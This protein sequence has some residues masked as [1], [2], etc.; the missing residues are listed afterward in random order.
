MFDF[1]IVGAGSAGCVLANRLSNGG[2]KVALI[3]AGGS[4]H[5][6]LKVRAP[7]LYQLLWS[8]P[9]DWAFKTK[10]QAHCAN[11]SH[12]WPRGKLIGGTSCLNAMVYIRG[13]RKNYDDWGVPG[14]SYA[15][16]LPY[17]KKSEDNVRGASEFHGAGGL[18]HVSNNDAPSDFAKAFVEATSAH[19]KVPVNDDFNGADQE[20]PGHYQS[21]IKKGQRAS[22]AIA[23]L[24]PALR[25]ENLT[26]MSGAHALGL[27]LDGDRVKGVRIRTAKGEQ[28][29]EG[30][31]IILAGGAIGS[32]HLLLLSG[33]GP[34]SELKAAGVEPKHELAGVGKNLQDHLLHAVNFEAASSPNLQKAAMLWWIA[35]FAMTGGGPLTGAALDA[36]AFIRSSPSAPLPDIQYHVA[37]FGV[38]LP[39]DHGVVNPSF[40]RFACILPGLIYPKSTGEICLASTDPTAPPA[41]DPK[42]F[43]DA[44]DLDLLVAGVKQS[45]EI[46]NT[47][48]LEQVLGKEIY[49]GP[50]ATSDEQLRDNI[51]AGCNT[52]FHPVGTCK[53]GTGSDAVVGPDLRV[54]GLR[55]LRVADA[56][57]MPK[58]VGGNT[59]APTIMIAEKCAELALQA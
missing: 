21:T 7:R 30:N 28:T 46:A 9:I 20:G 50:E 57:I 44:A 24:E 3:E 56:S 8:T 5:K 11:R 47:G 36:G 23:F 6:S 15:D 37:P 58:I 14:W 55:G 40:G 25:R 12:F 1:V 10:P 32:P 29:I 54:H 31:E 41:I 19:C 34:A 39:S 4:Q 51:R 48:A 17:F 2:R 59:N 22:T 53:M 52:I 26:V 16:V 45:R 43:S 13:N 18:L 27:V 38:K 49:P 33:I 42:Y 35:R